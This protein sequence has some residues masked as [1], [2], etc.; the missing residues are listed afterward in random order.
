MCR[1]CVEHGE[2]ERW[3]LNSANYAYDLVSDLERRDYIV[4]F[5]G[6]FGERREAALEWMHRLD[7][8][9]AP[10]S[11]VGK[12]AISHRMQRN[13]FGQPVPIEECDHILAISTSITVIPCICRMHT[14]G[15]RADEVCLLVTTQPIEAVLEAG[16]ADYANGPDASDFHRISREE[17]RVLLERCEADGL[18][19][20]IWTFKTPF[21]AAIC[22]CNLES[23]C[24]AMRMTAGHGL[25]LMWRGE[26]VAVLDDEKCIRCGACVRIC[27]F[28]SIAGNGTIK[29]RTEE[30]WGCGICRAACRHDAL[31]LVDRRSVPEVASLW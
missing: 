11:R 19:H 28:E 21:T 24:V 3:Y 7:S 10:L 23:G 13:H 29:V 6:G 25:K 14:P 2:G 9:P 5:I 22:N 20:S 12:S 17:A 15:K 8:L 18:M 30:C 31:K 16:F 1:F 27:P 26:S 4:D